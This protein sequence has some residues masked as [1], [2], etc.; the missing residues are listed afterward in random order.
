MICGAVRDG[1]WIGRTGTR[2]IHRESLRFRARKSER[3]RWRGRRR[4]RE[5]MWW[6]TTN[7]LP[8]LV[9]MLRKKCID[10]VFCLRLPASHLPHNRDWRRDG[11][12][13]RYSVAVQQASKCVRLQYQF[14]QKQTPRRRNYTSKFTIVFLEMEIMQWNVWSC[15]MCSLY[16][17]PQTLQYAECTSKR[18]DGGR[19]ETVRRTST[20]GIQSSRRS[21]S[22]RLLRRCRCPNET[23]KLVMVFGFAIVSVRFVWETNAS[24]LFVRRLINS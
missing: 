16:R 22:L 23:K 11:D 15:G 2:K 14:K 10:S 8:S 7:S 21:Q 17:V 5:M 4:R 6:P 19:V 3:E 1:R 24:C 9:R 13:H 12:R 20:A 18:P